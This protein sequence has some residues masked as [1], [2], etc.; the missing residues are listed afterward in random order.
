MEQY[1][2]N[3]PQNQPP[4]SQYTNP[5][6]QNNYQ[7]CPPQQPHPPQQGKPKKPVYKNGGSG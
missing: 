6:G 4:Q 2:Q 1:N 3:Q 7:S 5:A